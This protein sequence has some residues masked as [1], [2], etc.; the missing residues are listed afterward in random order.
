MGV[1]YLGF[2]LTTSPPIACALLTRKQS[3][4]TSYIS[5]LSDKIKLT[6]TSKEEEVILVQLKEPVILVWKA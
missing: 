4:G 5:L 1:E 6:R 3:F 2:A